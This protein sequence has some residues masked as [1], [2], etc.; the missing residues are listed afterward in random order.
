[1]R[2]SLV[3]DEKKVERE[4]KATSKKSTASNQTESDN[5]ASKKRP[6]KSKVKKTSELAENV[7]ATKEKKN[8]ASTGNDNFLGQRVKSTAG[9]PKE[10]NTTEKIVKKSKSAK[11][12]KASKPK[13]NKSGT[14]VRRVNVKT[15]INKSEASPAVRRVNSTR[16]EPDVV[17]GETSNA[18]RAKLVKI[19]ED[20]NLSPS[21]RVKAVRS[22]RASLAQKPSSKEPSILPQK[23]ADTMSIKE[24]MLQAPEK[25]SLAS[26]RGSKGKGSRRMVWQGLATPKPVRTGPMKSKPGFDI[27]SVDADGLRLTP[28]EVPQPPVPKLSYGL[29][30]VLFNPGVY[31]LQDPRSRVYNFDP[32]L[33]KIMPVS[34]FDFNALK[35]YITSSRDETLLKFAKGEGKKYTGS[36]SSMTAALSH[37]HFLLSQWRPINT[38]ALSQSF[39]VPYSSF[40]SLQRGPSAVFL[41]WKDGVYAIDADK[42]YDTANILSMLGKSMEKLLTLSTEDF[43]KYRRENSDQITEEQRNEAEAFNYT[44]IGDFLLRSQL[45]AYD[46][47][48]PGSGMFDLKTRAVVSIRMD[49]QEYEQGMG[50]EI[51]GRHGEYESFEREYYDMIRAAFLKYSLQVRMGRMDGIFVAFHNTQRIFGFQYISLSEMDYALH[52]TDDTT[53]G[54]LEFKLSLDLLNRVLDKASAKYP[55]KSLRLHFETRGSETPFMYVFAEPMEEDEIQSLQESNKASILEFERNILG[56]DIKTEEELLEE[57]KNAEWQSLRAKVEES[58]KK[59]EFDIQEARKFAETMMEESDSILGELSAEEK[60]KFMDEL[61]ASFESIDHGTESNTASETEDPNNEAAEEDENGA[62]AASETEDGDD[63][64]E[65]AN[66]DDIEDGVDDEDD[67]EQ[68][69]EEEAEEEDEDEE[70]EDEDEDED[71][72]GQEHEEGGKEEDDVEKQSDELVETENNELEIGD[73]VASQFESDA[74][75]V[76]NVLKDEQIDKNE[77]ATVGLVE[78]EQLEP[79]EEEDLLSDNDAEGDSQLTDETAMSEALQQDQAATE[80]DNTTAPPDVLAMTLTIRNKVNGHYIERPVTLSK[81]DN[82]TVEYALAEVSEP[83]RARLLYEATKRRRAAVLSSEKSDEANPWNDEYVARLRALS[84]KGQEWRENQSKLEEVEGPPKVLNLVEDPLS[85]NNSEN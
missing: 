55:E 24:G 32:Y 30:R 3:A 36:T 76:R 26:D 79:Q 56:L 31:H 48:L 28:L 21:D 65:D 52:G 42:Q 58:M 33:A 63:D 23:V 15:A 7:E 12:S 47:R 53:I 83:G 60:E 19:I 54:D 20:G 67:E 6:K 51:K 62:S 18:A 10:S 43:E 14:A 40:T 34:E 82:W 5:A 81:E 85:K 45:D 41:R 38:G 71:E 69:E 73:T 2:N 44:T 64:I 77:H 68:K 37:F 61:M 8:D 9:K 57:R 50:Y 1:M 72:E 13:V 80:V 11:S 70:N 49:A 35:Q 27:K 17:V 39:P 46:P 75:V 25:K 84:R 29:E 74:D 78:N 16:A 22:L 66:E 4:R 59:D